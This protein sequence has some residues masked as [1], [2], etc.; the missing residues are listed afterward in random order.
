MAKKRKM[1]AKYR[2]KT[3]ARRDMKRRKAKKKKGAK[4]APAIETIFLTS[5]AERIIFWILMITMILAM[6]THISLLFHEVMLVPRQYD[7]ETSFAKFGERIE[8]MA[9]FYSLLA[10]GAALVLVTLRWLPRALAWHSYDFEWLS[11]LGGYGRKWAKIPPAGRFNPEQKIATLGL[12]LFGALYVVSGVVQEM[13]MF[14]GENITLVRT[15]YSLHAFC[16]IALGFVALM[17]MYLAAFARPG[18]MGA[19][20]SGRVSK[21]FAETHYSIWYEQS[22]ESTKIKA[23]KD[24]R[25]HGKYVEMEKQH[26]KEVMAKRKAKIKAKAAG[27]V[28]EEEAVE[29][30]IVPDIEDEAAEV[31][32]IETSEDEEYEEGE[33]EEGESEEGEYDEKAFQEEVQDSATFDLE[34]VEGEEEGEE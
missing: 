24:R 8:R 23:E 12:M 21:K 15:S 1:T 25:R 6:L 27:V 17:H 10:F 20:W 4:E 26:I 33:Y 5:K 28:P 30:E 16:L 31:E 11:D 14:V 7:M 18:G 34:P 3:D 2:S 13:P 32:E 19:I 22:L 9:H 29:M